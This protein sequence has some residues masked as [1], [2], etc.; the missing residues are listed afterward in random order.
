MRLVA[1]RSA[2]LVLAAFVSVHCGGVEAAPSAGDGGPAHDSAPGVDAGGDAAHPGPLPPP[3]NHRPAP[4]GCSTTRPP[5]IN[6]D[7][8]AGVDAGGEGPCTNDSQCTAGTNGRCT[9]PQHNGFPTCQ[10]DQCFTD[11]QCGKGGVCECGQPDGQGRDPNTCLNGNCSV[12]SDCGPG[13]Y[14][15]PSY[16]TTCGAYDGVVGYY[17]HTAGD[18]CTNDEQCTGEGAGYCAYQPTTGHWACDYGFCAG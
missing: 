3:T 9:P 10:Y 4:V 14:C 18:L 16:D 1:V 7:A 17:C 13:G 5:G 2:A 15:S 6:E 11:S 12:D 8:G